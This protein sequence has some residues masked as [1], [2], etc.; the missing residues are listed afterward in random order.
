MSP[1]E[2]E[3]TDLERQMAS[4]RAAVVQLQEDWLKRQDELV[5]LTTK[6]DTIIEKNELL[7]KGIYKAY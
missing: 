3:V 6:R 4:E 2:R 1:M 7:R 5:K